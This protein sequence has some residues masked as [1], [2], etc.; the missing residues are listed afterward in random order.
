MLPLQEPT[1]PMTL[2]K[3]QALHILPLMR[4]AEKNL[5]IDFLRLFQVSADDLDW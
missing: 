4:G 1:G 3:A 2:D 5:L